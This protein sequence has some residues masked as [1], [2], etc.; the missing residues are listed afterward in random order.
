MSASDRKRPAMALNPPAIIGTK[1]VRTHNDSMDA[2]VKTEETQEGI[3]NNLLLPAASTLAGNDDLKERFLGVFSDPKY[4]LGISN[5][6]LKQVF[7][8]DFVQLAAIINDLTSHMRLT[9]SQLSSGELFFTL[10]STED[11]RKFAGLDRNAKM[12]YQ[13]VEKAGN[14]GVWTKDVRIQTNIQQAALTKIFKALEN[15]HLIKPV[16]SVV[17]RA[18]KLYMLYDVQPSKEL[19]GGVW[20]SDLEFDHAFVNELRTFLLHCIRKLHSGRGVTLTELQATMIQAN[21]SRVQLSVKDV[22]QIVRTLQYDGLCERVHGEHDRG[23]SLICAAKRVTSMCEFTWW[24]VLAPDFHFR[25][26]RF[27][28]DDV[29]LPPQEPHYHT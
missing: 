6:E 21:V 28:D 20:Y 12:V 25:A 15:R 24:E 5:S 3:N 7:G 10:H 17:A 16:K 8:T 27:E 29:V 18:K 26:V 23:E 1:R 9:L 22:E 11:A 13:M 19:T 4:T 14:K 2:V